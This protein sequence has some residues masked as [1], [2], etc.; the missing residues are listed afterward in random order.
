MY[1]VRK[2]AI[3]YYIWDRWQNKV[4]NFFTEEEEAVEECELLNEKALLT[5]SQGHELNYE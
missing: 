3:L 5:R 1:E 2:G 4:I